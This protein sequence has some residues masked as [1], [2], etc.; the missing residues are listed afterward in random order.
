MSGILERIETKLDRLIAVLADGVTLPT[1][2]AELLDAGQGLSDN[3]AGNSAQLE[4]NKQ[5]APAASID[6]YAGVDKDGVTW[7]AR[8]HSKADVPK[9]VT[10]GKWKMRRGLQPGVYDNIMAELKASAANF[11]DAHVPVNENGPFFWMDT[12]TKVSNTCD[13]RAEMDKLLRIPTTKELTEAEFD[14]LLEV[15][16]VGPK[17]PLAPKAPTA[18]APKAPAAPVANPVK[19][20]VL[21]LIKSLTD[22][23][24]AEPNDIT[25][26]MV[27]VTGFDTIGKIADDKLEVFRDTLAIWDDNVSNAQQAVTEMIAIADPLGFTENLNE[28]IEGILEPHDADCVGLVHYSAIAGVNDQLQAYLKT[29]QEL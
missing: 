9:S 14:A 28:G 17:A 8:I 20:E 15:P 6:P 19:T 26:L 2:T 27:E 3:E 24:R 18:S 22:E 23:H 5:H 16:A 21:N 4:E 7:D 13:T 10:T 12:A 11:E 1:A 25:N 29:W